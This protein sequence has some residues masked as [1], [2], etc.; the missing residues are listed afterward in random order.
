MGLALGI[1]AGLVRVLFFFYSEHYSAAEVWYF[2]ANYFR[3][4]VN[5]FVLY[6]AGLGLAL[7]VVW[8]LFDRMEGLIVSGLVVALPFLPMVYFVN[9]NYFPER[10]EPVSLVGNGLF[11]LTMAGLTF[12]LFFRFLLNLHFF[13]GFNHVA[14]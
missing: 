10:Y 8:I 4:G 3:N 12:L 11:L 1:A 7:A 6:G 14:I 13:A 9:K 2:T 5:P